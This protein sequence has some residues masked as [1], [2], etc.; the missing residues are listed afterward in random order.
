MLLLL[1][2]YFSANTFFALLKASG[3]SKFYLVQFINYY[4]YWLFINTA[5]VEQD[6]HPQQSPVDKPDGTDGP[7][8]RQ[9][10]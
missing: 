10:I 1:L 6:I 9:N 4:Y 8:S 5:A 7:L 3:V 2:I